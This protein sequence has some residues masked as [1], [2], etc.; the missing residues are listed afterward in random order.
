MAMTVSAFITELDS[1]FPNDYTDTSKVGWINDVE[2]AVSEDIDREF[3]ATYYNKINGVYQYTLPTGVLWKDVYKVFVDDREY[4]KKSL[5]HNKNL[6]SFYLDNSKLNIYPV[7]DESDPEYVSGASEITFKAIEYVSGSGE[8]TFASGTITTTGDSFVTAGFVVG[9]S[10]QITGCTVNTGNNTTA[11]ITAV[12]AA[13]ITVA[14]GTFT[15]GAETGM[16]TIKTN[17]IYTSGH[18]FDGFTVGEMALVSG[19]T[20]ETANNK[21]ARIIA[22]ADDV[23]TFAEDTFTAQAETAAVTIQQ[24]S[25]K[26]IY[27]YRPTEKDVDDIETDELTLPRRF[28]DIYYQYCYAQMSLLNREF[29]EYNNYISIYNVLVA[30]YLAWYEERRDHSEVNVQLDGTYASIED[31]D[32]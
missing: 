2:F 15:A 6:Y 30:E 23:L 3:R 7:P 32:D 19:C 29:S 8:L 22:I 10:I 28:Q 18:D 26:M 1:R 9:N 24:P 11:V 27:R 12:A 13:T 16:V 20:D 4:Y 25:I 17:C 21:Y 14:T 31:Y 5:L